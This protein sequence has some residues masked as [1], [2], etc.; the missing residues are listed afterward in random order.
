M[1]KSYW[2]TWRFLQKWGPTVD[3][4]EKIKLASC[5]KKEKWKGRSLG[6]FVYVCEYNSEI[7]SPYIILVSI[8]YVLNLCCLF[9][10]LYVNEQQNF[11]EKAKHQSTNSP[12]KPLWKSCLLVLISLTP[13]KVEHRFYV[14]WSLSTLILSKKVSIL[15]DT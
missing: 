8:I 12:L 3:Q 7:P 15:L 1:F 5:N 2:F 11:S 10:S 9:I 6:L 4:L 14:S 13:W